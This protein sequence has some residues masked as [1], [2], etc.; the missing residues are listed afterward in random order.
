MKRFIYLLPF[1]FLNLS[2]S[3]DSSDD[4]PENEIENSTFTVEYSQSGDNLLFFQDITFYGSPVG[5]ENS[6]SGAEVDGYL[7]SEEEALPISFSYTTK[8]T[9]PAIWVAYNVTPH[10]VEEDIS[11]E[12]AFKIYKDGE[13]IDTKN[14]SIDNKSTVTDS[15]EWK[16]F[17]DVGDI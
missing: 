4:L 13:L 16:Y 10:N 8:Q 2:C 11:L 6:D 3:D 12:V 14:L 15:F 9:T 1:L 7:N 5:W 17:A